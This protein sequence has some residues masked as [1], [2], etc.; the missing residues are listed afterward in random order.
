VI[1]RKVLVLVGHLLPGLA[2]PLYS[3]CLTF[4]NLICLQEF[5][6]SST[7]RATETTP[8]GKRHLPPDQEGLGPVERPWEA[9]LGRG[10]GK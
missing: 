3:L 6:S 2:I 7:S 5:K 1:R 8:V 9:Q 4:S 10:R